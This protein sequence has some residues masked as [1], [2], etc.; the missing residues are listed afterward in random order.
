MSVSVPGQFQ[1]LAS[2]LA[3]LFATEN[4][5]ILRRIFL[6]LDP[7]SLHSAFAVNSQWNTYLKEK[8]TNI[9]R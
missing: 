6:N 4:N 1:D 2:F 5:L 8:G 7:K 3:Y 9:N